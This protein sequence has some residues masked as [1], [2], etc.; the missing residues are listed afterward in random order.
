MSPYAYLPMLTHLVCL[1]TLTYQSSTSE[2]EGSFMWSFRDATDS[3][4]D[5]LWIFRELPHAQR[6]ANFIS[7]VKKIQEKSELDCGALKSALLQA[8][9]S[10]VAAAAAASAKAVQT[11]ER[12]QRRVTTQRIGQNVL[13]G[14][15]E[16]APGAPM[17]PGYVVNVDEEHDQCL[18]R[19][20]DGGY[21]R[22]IIS[23]SNFIWYD[24]PTLRTTG[25]PLPLDNAHVGTV[26]AASGASASAAERGG[27][28]AEAPR[29][30]D[31]TPRSGLELL[32]TC[33]IVFEPRRWELHCACPAVA[34]AYADQLGLRAHA[35]RG[36]LQSSTSATEV[37]YMQQALAEAINLRTNITKVV[38]ETR[39][40]HRAQQLQR[41]K[42]QFGL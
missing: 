12:A 11:C 40:I 14:T 25:A 2:Y 1:H 17:Q 37:A 30:A 24:N 6:P 34:M 4:D 42:V 19:M 41:A 18:I 16:L 31:A 29:G 32:W 35:L 5:Q 15:R 36:A 7:L 23:N 21:S 26:A 39:A 8:A 22:W 13:V 33:F 27:S 3:G 9:S 28:A 10:G 20:R 38:Y